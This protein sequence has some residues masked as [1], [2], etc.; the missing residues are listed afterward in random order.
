MKVASVIRKP[1]RTENVRGSTRGIAVLAFLCLLILTSVLASKVMRKKLQP[2]PVVKVKNTVESI[3]ALYGNSSRS[4][5]KPKFENAKLSYPP[6]KLKLLGLKTEKLLEIYAEGE[7]HQIRYVC[8]Y[9]ILGTSGVLGPK[10]REGD[11]QMPEGFY[12]IREFEPNSSYHIA[13]RVDYPSPFDKEMG[14]Q[15]GR[16]KLGS[17]IMIHGKDR[18][19]GC[20]AMGD[21]GAEDIF[22]LVHDVGLD[23]TELI[24]SPFRFSQATTGSITSGS[25]NMDGKCLYFTKETGNSATKC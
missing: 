18:S 10:Q 23:N 2:A 3:V 24:M 21:P 22:V 16:E 20:L 6:K 5:L 19:V 25:A 12:R 15:D 11:K 1:A 17:D 4:R 7:D 9:P 13:L 8:T 14:K